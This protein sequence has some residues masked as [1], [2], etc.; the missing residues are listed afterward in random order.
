MK[1]QRLKRIKFQAKITFKYSLASSLCSSNI[2]FERSLFGSGGAGRKC[3]SSIKW[4]DAKSSSS[5]PPLVLG[6]FWSFL[7]SNAS[8]D[9]FGEVLIAVWFVVDWPIR[10][11]ALLEVDAIALVLDSVT[12]I[13][14]LLWLLAVK[15]TE[16]NLLFNFYSFHWIC[17]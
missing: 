2:C 15:K 11:R 12:D 4:T 9:G 7:P 10:V 1:I 8:F 13:R 6:I 3:G 16:R 14:S 17:F 5:T